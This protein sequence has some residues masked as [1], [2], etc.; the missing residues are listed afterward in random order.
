MTTTNSNI[1]IVSAIFNQSNDQT[2]DQS[3][4]INYHSP[5]LQFLFNLDCDCILFYSGSHF[6]T[7][8]KYLATNYSHITLFPLNSTIDLNSIL[9]LNS[10]IDQNTSDTNITHINTNIYELPNN[11]G[12]SD[13]ADYI[14]NTH[15]KIAC[16]YYAVNHIT[17]NNPS[18]Y[19]WLDSDFLSLLTEKEQLDTSSLLQNIAFQ[20]YLN[21]PDQLILP[22]YDNV[23]ILPTILSK[24]NMDDLLNNVHWRFF[25]TMII[26]NC[27]SI[28]A[29]WKLYQ[30]HFNWFINEYKLIR[31]VN[32]WAWLE[33]NH[34]INGFK[35]I[36]YSANLNYS[37]FTNIPKNIYSMN[38]LTNNDQ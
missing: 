23:P 26:G 31:S 2:N 22:G 25:G 19:I 3:N 17:K 18:A 6:H 16:L 7:L 4:E 10:T 1:I 37:I 28:R 15:L 5:F 11:R 35:P 33:S 21:I 8:S 20:E 9:P 36:Q 12:I 29:I 24:S 34:T 32:F 30:K 13:T 38:L 27:N 14:M